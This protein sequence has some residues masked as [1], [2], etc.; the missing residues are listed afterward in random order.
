MPR[1]PA[2]KAPPHYRR[3]YQ[4]EDRNVDSVITMLSDRLQTHPMVLRCIKCRLQHVVHRPELLIK[5]GVCNGVS[6]YKPGVLFFLWVQL[7]W[8]LAHRASARF[9]PSWEAM[10]FGV[11]GT[12]LYEGEIATITRYETAINAT[13]WPVSWPICERTNTWRRRL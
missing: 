8:L 4:P 6:L 10:R 5:C 3:A 1:K 7:T 11:I 9:D 12:I 13:D 2:T